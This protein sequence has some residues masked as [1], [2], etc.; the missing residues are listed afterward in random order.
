MVL[1]KCRILDRL[2]LGYQYIYDS[3]RIS[4]FGR[5][6]RVLATAVR[7]CCLGEVG[8]NLR[9]CETLPFLCRSPYG[10][11]LFSPMCLRI[12]TWSMCFCECLSHFRVDRRVGAGMQDMSLT[13][14]T[15]GPFRG[16]FSCLGRTPPCW[17]PVIFWFFSL[18]ALVIFGLCIRYIRYYTRMMISGG[19]VSSILLTTL[20]RWLD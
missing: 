17:K 8:V 15:E 18:V 9:F 10:F 11:V 13:A 20:C 12:A 6:R 19:K 4:A 1:G 7:H 16:A 3:G 2:L 5:Q 14:W